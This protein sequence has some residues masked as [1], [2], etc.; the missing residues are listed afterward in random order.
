MSWISTLDRTN[1]FRL[2]EIGTGDPTGSSLSG[3]DDVNGDDFDHLINAPKLATTRQ[4]HALQ[5]NHLRSD[6]ASSDSA[7]SESHEPCKTGSPQLRRMTR[8]GSLE[9]DVSWRIMSRLRRFGPQGRLAQSASALP[10]HGRG[11]R[12]KSC[13]VHFATSCSCKTCRKSRRP[14][15]PP[16]RHSKP[17]D[18]RPG[19]ENA[20]GPPLVAAVA[21]RSVFAACVVA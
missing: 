5:A 16:P 10:S 14:G 19:I 18:A 7:S 1:G 12:F 15:L 4:E 17:S 9:S 8:V 11:H 20:S 2:N 21:L 3:A 6:S 13:S